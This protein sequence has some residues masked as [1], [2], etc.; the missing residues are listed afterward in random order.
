MENKS[1]SFVV[2]DET[3]NAYGSVILTDGID[4]TDFLKNPVM[5]YNHDRASGIIGRWE[6][7]RKEGAKL[8]AN[9]V[10]DTSS[11]LG[12]KVY[13]QVI[14]NFIRTASIAV[15]IL[16]QEDRNGVI[17]V[18]RC[19]LV[20]ISIVDIPANS[21]AVKMRYC[22]GSVLSESELIQKIKRLL[23]LEED[24]EAND[25]LNAIQELKE[26]AKDIQ[27]QDENKEIEN[28]LTNNLIARSEIKAFRVLYRNDKQEFRQYL[29]IK[30][31]AYENELQQLVRK[32]VKDGKILV[33]EEEL[34]TELGKK[35]GLRLLKRVLDT[36]H[37]PA[38]ISGFLA[39]PKDKSNWTLDDY[40]KFAPNELANNKELYRTLLEKA[41]KGES[42]K[43]LEWYRKNAPDYLAANPE[44]YKM[45]INK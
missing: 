36:L 30:A 17:Y 15:D 45:L 32:A 28:A 37:G 22:L 20:E 40:R 38:K 33:Y 25:I 8:V 4:I 16:E 10:F 27:N 1:I 9:A 7:I 11:E 18:T 23:G 26:A 43:D 39:L 21:N 41:G 3:V 29:K 44:F 34:Y 6:N 19:K 31:Q 13:N 2:S 5:F 14:N 42:I 35:C 12:Q 24:T